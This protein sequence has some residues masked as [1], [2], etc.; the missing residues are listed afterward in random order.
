MDGP[1]AGNCPLGS[2]KILGPSKAI[3]RRRSPEAA[4]HS[5]WVNRKFYGNYP[6]ASQ[7]DAMDHAAIVFFL[8]PRFP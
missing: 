3:D 5:L 2:F 7:R 4:L 8:R 6:I 1:R